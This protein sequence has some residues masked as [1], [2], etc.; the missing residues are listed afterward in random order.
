MTPMPWPDQNHLQA[1]E[2]W[3]GLGNP[4]E[5]NEELERITPEHRVHPAVLEIRWQIYAQAK[6]W[7]ACL[8]IAA[9]ITKLAPKSPAGS[10]DGGNFTRK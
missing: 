9:A 1:A 5:A 6:K 3:L 7:P 4:H 8:D 10:L 2:G